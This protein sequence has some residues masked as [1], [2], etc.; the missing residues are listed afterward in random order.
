MKIQLTYPNPPTSTKLIF[1]ISSTVCLAIVMNSNRKND[2]LTG[3]GVLLHL[4]HIGKKNM[5]IIK[6]GTL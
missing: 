5:K 4:L 3:I 1:N 2:V 6:Q